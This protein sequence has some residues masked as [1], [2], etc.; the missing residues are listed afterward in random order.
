MGPGNATVS[1]WSTA[2]QVGTPLA[3]A[4]FVVAVVGWIL[5]TRVKERTRRIESAPP[6]ERAALVEATLSTYRIKQD[7]LTREQKFE[8]LK[9]ELS[10]R[11]KRT[12]YVLV[13]AGFVALLLAIVILAQVLVGDSGST[14]LPGRGP[15]SP[16]AGVIRAVDLEKAAVFPRVANTGKE[17]FSINSG[18]LAVTCPGSS[19]VKVTLKPRDATKAKVLANDEARLELG[20][21]FEKYVVPL[22]DYRRCGYR[23]TLEA[24]N[25]TSV[26]TLEKQSAPEPSAPSSERVTLFEFS[27]A[28]E[29]RQT[30]SEYASAV[31]EA[32]RQASQALE[33]G[34]RDVEVLELSAEETG[35]LVPQTERDLAAIQQQ[36]RSL[37][38]AS[39]SVSR[40][41]TGFRVRSAMFAGELSRELRDGLLRVA[42]PFAGADSFEVARELNEIAVY[43][44]LASSLAKQRGTQ[45]TIVGYLRHA[46]NSA[47]SMLLKAG[48]PDDLRHLAEAWRKFLG[49]CL[50]SAKRGGATWCA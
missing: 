40:E 24:A 37:L 13:L 12:L 30:Y 5:H 45:E 29:S 16:P 31:K 17:P 6:E 50:T 34:N 26:V 36:S 27:G 48:L 9:G 38:L 20:A 3:L 32:V 22:P 2:T 41:T 21:R 23:L 28:G 11:E 1:L 42:I 43:Y 14:V 39:G 8:L 33:E 35:G 47:G 7:N 4:A 44:C 46:D 19:P 25:G 10:A 18:E 49:S 15:S